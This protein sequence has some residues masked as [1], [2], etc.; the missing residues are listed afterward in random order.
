[1]IVHK[2]GREDELYAV[3]YRVY[4][5]LAGEG[6]LVK[7][8]LWEGPYTLKIAL[9]RADTLKIAYQDD[10]SFKVKTYKGN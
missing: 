5:S 9:Q 4:G 1:M 8:Y 10:D 6:Q 7:D 3:Y 2:P